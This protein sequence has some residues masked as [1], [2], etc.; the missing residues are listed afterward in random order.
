MLEDTERVPEARGRDLHDVPRSYWI[1]PLFI[2]SY[3][4]TGFGFMAATGGYALIAP[5]LGTINNELG[6]SPN[7][8]W[9]ALANL[10]CQAVTFLLVGRLSDIFGRRWF[11]IIGSIIGLIGSIVGATAQSVEQLIGAEVF[12]GIAA[13]FQISFFW[14]V[15]EIVPMKYRYLAN[16]GAY[17]FTIPTNPLAP[18]IAFAFQT[19][20]K[21]KWRGCFYFMIAVNVLSI[22]CWY[23]FYHP[24]TFKMLHRRKAAKDMLAHFDWIGLILY[25]GSTLVFL[26]GLT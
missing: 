25:A 21:V 9:I 24:P 11:F 5:L 20:T 18:K 26:I 23:A 1:S 13:G 10:L 4:A 17:A 6:P 2:G 22:F 14:V 19:Q 12:P 15:S 3:C 8:T 16:S 7:V